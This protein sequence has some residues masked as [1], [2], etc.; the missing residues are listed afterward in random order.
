MSTQKDPLD[1][2][3]HIQ[4][5]LITKLLYSTQSFRVY[6]AE[7]MQ[8]D[9]E[10]LLYEFF[11]DHKEQLHN[12]FKAL[13]ELRSNDIPNIYKIF[14]ENSTLYVSTQY[15]SN[16]KILQEVTT[17]TTLSEQELALIAFE[18]ITISMAYQNV[19]ARASSLSPEIILYD[20]IRSKCHIAYAELDTLEHERD[21]LYQIGKLLHSLMKGK[22]Q[23]GTLQ[24]LEANEIYSKSFCGLINRMLFDTHT[25]YI[26]LSTAKN[27]LKSYK[28]RTT[29][30]E[31]LVCK[32]KEKSTFSSFTSLASIFIVTIFIIY[33][34]TR[35]DRLDHNNITQIDLA[36][37]FVAAY[38]GSTR[39]QNALGDLYDNGYI[40]NQDK[41]EALY[42]YEK[43]LNNGDIWAKK[44]VAYIYSQQKD[45]P[46]KL[47]KAI[48]YFKELAQKG[49]SYAQ[50]NLA[51]LYADVPSEDQDLLKAAA[52]FEQAA[53]L[54]DNN[55][56]IWLSN[57][58]VDNK[59][60]KKAKK[61]FEALSQKEN[62]YAQNYLGYMY[63]T[64]KG[65]TKDYEQARFWFEKASA[66]G[67]KYALKGLE[68]IKKE[69]EWQQKQKEKEKEKERLKQEKVAQQKVRQ[70]RQKEIQNTQKRV[71]K[72]P[73]KQEVLQQKTEH[74]PQSYRNY[75]DYGEYI[76]DKKTGLL[77][78][79]NG[80]ISG[81]L[82]FYQAAQY[83]KNLS[84]GNIK[85]WRVPTIKELASIF[86]A[87][88]KP[89][90]GNV[91]T[92][93]STKK[94]HS[95]WTS[96]LDTRLDDYAYI[97]QW[98]DAGGANNGYASRNYVYVRCVHD[99]ID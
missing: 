18:L 8:R 15:F 30:C 85:G 25:E 13:Q 22:E 65:V 34:S 92:T 63:L 21:A 10:T 73:I 57:H 37:Y 86:P 68:A 53:L 59:N 16:M 17:D 97:Y 83:A 14:Q 26:K 35:P 76:K 79:K 24:A 19:G 56:Q 82:N 4:E 88:Q 9:R 54:G 61:H 81:R 62:T 74:F 52:W 90:T 44:K 23:E 48:E 3:S 78:Q 1:I 47:K 66:K 43:S 70:Q 80:T 5:Y 41:K 33:L 93:N 98:Y 45:D 46:K 28:A 84:L 71:Q 11:A 60:L 91:Y 49:D 27:L 50:V 39:A 6:L 99:P 40:L 77:W 51:K 32:E 95:Y 96:E 75:I 94:R 12:Y 69:K 42:W 89:F 67:D 2:R 87:T 36:Q 29:E 7:D 20:P 58:Y 72:T 55:A 38:F 64:G 31:P